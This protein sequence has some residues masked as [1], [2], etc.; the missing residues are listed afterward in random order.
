MTDDI[1]ERPDYL[2]D[3]PCAYHAALQEQLEVV[4]RQS[5]RIEEL[6]ALALRRLAMLEIQ[7][8]AVTHYKAQIEELEAE[9][10]RTFSR[11]GKTGLSVDQYIF[12][13]KGEIEALEGEIEE[14]E[15]NQMTIIPGDDAVRAAERERLK[16]W[17]RHPDACESWLSYGK[18]NCGLDAALGEDGD[19]DSLSRRG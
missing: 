11:G 15:A 17:L 19:R 1:K 18:C 5:D 16:P 3:P 13:L 12:E 10:N 2:C 9:V 6:E 8:K 7:E 4:Q 14:L